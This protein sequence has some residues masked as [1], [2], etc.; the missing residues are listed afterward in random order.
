MALNVTQSDPSVHLSKRDISPR[1]FWIITWNRIEEFLP[2]FLSELFPHEKSPTQLLSPREA[3]PSRTKDVGTDQV[4]ERPNSPQEQRDQGSGQLSSPEGAAL[5]G[6][7]SPTPASEG[8]PPPAPP[9]DQT[10]SP[11]VS[12]GSSPS[13]SRYS[14]GQ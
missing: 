13:H 11:T 9:A 4:E 3:S 8:Q 2:N 14:P 1:K 5:S 12:P 10:S 6:P 7:P